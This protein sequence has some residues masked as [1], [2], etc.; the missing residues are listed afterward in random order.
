MDDL[1]KL[2]LSDGLIDADSNL[3]DFGHKMVSFLRSSDPHR[4]HQI[5]CRVSLCMITDR[6][7]NGDR[8]QIVLRFLPK[9]VRLLELADAAKSIGQSFKNRNPKYL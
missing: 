7:K 9:G 5:A 6:F 1:T 4:S 2:L 8:E 3:T